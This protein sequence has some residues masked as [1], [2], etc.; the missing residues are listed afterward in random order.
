MS[1]GQPLND[2]DREPWLL[3]IRRTG[4]E[5]AL[6]QHQPNLPKDGEKKQ[7]AEVLE[8]SHQETTPV[9]ITAAKASTTTTSSNSTTTTESDKGQWGERSGVAVIACSSLKLV[10]RRLL[11]GT[12]TSLSDPAATQPETDA[13]EPAD[14]RV[15]HVF[16]DLSRQL[17]EERMANRKGHFMKLDM[18]YSQ[19]DTLQPPTP[20]ESGTVIVKV[21][22]ETSTQAIVAEAMR[23][24]KA[25]HVI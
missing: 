24:L 25:Q 1:A 15:V 8:T 22:R 19:L 2:A 6:T 13:G 21:Q 23:Q 18:L 20:S 14:L 3:K 10:Y 17:L 11:R 5:L 4:L 16:L 9:D 7:L 12:I